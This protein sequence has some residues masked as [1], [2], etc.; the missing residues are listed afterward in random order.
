MTGHDRL[1]IPFPVEP[2]L[3]LIVTHVHIDHVDPALS[4]GRW[5]QA[6]LPNQ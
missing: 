6:E 5:L 4:A 3:A 2:I 1:Q